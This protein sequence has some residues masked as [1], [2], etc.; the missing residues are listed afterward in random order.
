MCQDVDILVPA[1]LENQI[2]PCSCQQI[3]P[4]VKIL[5][6]GANGPVTPDTDPLLK[7]RDII[8]LPDFLCNA[9][10]VTCSYFEQ[11]QCNMNYFWSKEE[12]MEKLEVSMTNA[13]NAVNELAQE[14]NLTLREAAYVIAINRVVNAVKLR[15]WV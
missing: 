10:G 3:S 6:E 2:I 9:G 5:C 14:K 8:V 15:G 12:V 11:V 4:K 1:A 13:F 7:D